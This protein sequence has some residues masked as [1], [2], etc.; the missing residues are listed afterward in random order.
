M[1]HEDL[2]GSAYP[3]VTLMGPVITTDTTTGMVGLGQRAL[4]AGL[5]LPPHMDTNMVGD[6]SAHGLITA[7]D[8][9]LHSHMFIG[10]NP[11]PQAPL[12]STLGPLPPDHLSMPAS[13]MEHQGY[14]NMPFS[15]A[16]SLMMPTNSTYTSMT[17]VPPSSFVPH[18]NCETLPQPMAETQH[19][20]DKSSPTPVTPYG[21]PQASPA[22]S[23]PYGH[24]QP[25]PVPTNPYLNSQPSPAPTNPYT[26]SQ[27][28]PAPTNPYTNSTPSPA[29]TNPYAQ[30]SPSPAPT[31]PYSNNPQPSPVP[32]TL[33]GQ[34]KASNSLP[35]PAPSNLNPQPDPAPADPEDPNTALLNHHQTPSPTPMAEHV[36]AESVNHR[37]ENGPSHEIKDPSVCE[38]GAPVHQE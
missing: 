19:S 8:A 3:G 23:N 15:L 20:H 13:L 4:N 33:S 21:H 22:P 30:S 18:E 34:V 1:Q 36:A 28:S 14:Q 38:R 6:T 10:H 27:P 37:T 24:T 17:V 25:S 9:A 2:A 31:N 5:G 29:T 26:N 32:V 16:T 7:A 35:S 12:S 11:S